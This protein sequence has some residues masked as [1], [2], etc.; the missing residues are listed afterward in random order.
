MGGSAKPVS[1]PT[2]GREISVQVRVPPIAPLRTFNHTC[3]MQLKD[4]LTA[5]AS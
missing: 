5:D 4:Q 3:Q 1:R 2:W